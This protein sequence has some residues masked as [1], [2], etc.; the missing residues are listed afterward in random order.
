MR[1]KVSERAVLFGLG[2]L[3]LVSA[4]YGASNYYIESTLGD[5]IS[6]WF[7]SQEISFREGNVLTAVSNSQ[8]SVEHSGA[9]KGIAV[10]D[11][12]FHPAR[13]LV[14]FGERL[15]PVLLSAAHQ[16]TLGN[17]VAL[18]LF[19]YSTIRSVPGK[20]QLAILF[21]FEPE[22]AKVFFFAYAVILLSIVASLLIAFRRL[23]LSEWTKREVI[24]K[25]LNTLASQVA[26]DI[27]SPLA[28]LNMAIRDVG[29][30]P[31]DTRVLIQ[32]A[33]KRINDIANNLL[34]KNRETETRKFD[35]L[36]SKGNR[37][38][39]LPAVIDSLVSE[40]RLEFRNRPSLDLNYEVDA[41]SYGI[42]VEIWDVELKRLLSNLI[43]NA[44]EAIDGPGYITVSLSLVQ[45]FVELRIQDS[46]RGVSEKVLSNLGKRGVTYGKQYGSGLGLYYAKTTV[47]KFGGQLTI[48]SEQGK[49][50]SVSLLFPVVKSPD[51]FVDRINLSRNATVAVADD[52]ESIHR[53][54]KQRFDFSKTCFSNVKLHSFFSLSQ[55]EEWILKFPE[56]SDL[57][58]IDHEFF[59]SPETGIEFIVRANLAERSVLVTSR[60][61]D[62]QIV[63][64]CSRFKIRVMP[65]SLACAVPIDV[66]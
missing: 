28:A 63:E 41:E 16:E 33:T 45:N 23:E 42:F 53:I 10:L 31:E 29:A 20:Q 51:W 49:G 56:T 5:F 52:D 37:V 4:S 8:R 25:K 57:F 44:A 46:G 1:L 65:K 9:L 13:E 55:L 60:F 21:I 34:Q 39:L 22:Y 35:R 12:S 15:T 6:T 66:F 2:S 36:L 61:E 40:K 11:L 18:G 7:S 17:W 54:W 47:K 43:N 59:G 38:A 58:L 26:H 30:I 24:Q 32:T 27:R 19:K 48:R 62:L 64:Q 14:S 3:L 50:T